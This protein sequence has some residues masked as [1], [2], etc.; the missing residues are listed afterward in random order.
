MARDSSRD[1]EVSSENYIIK[2]FDKIF[3]R[4]VVA[5][6]LVGA[7][8]GD[9]SKILFRRMFGDLVGSIIG[10]GFSVLVFIYWRYIESVQ[11]IAMEP[12]R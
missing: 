9:I 12:V 7:H 8:L 2:S 1:D 4:S 5:G 6:T 11:E 3:S 10:L